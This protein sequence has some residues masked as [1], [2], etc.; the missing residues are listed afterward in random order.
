MQHPLDLYLHSLEIEQVVDNTVTPSK[1]YQSSSPPQ[2]IFNNIKYDYVTSGRGP[3]GP[4]G[5]GIPGVPGCPGKPASPGL[6]LS[7]GRPG[8]PYR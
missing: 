6:P 8:C 7:P 4:G 5:P 2:T 1:R 3:G